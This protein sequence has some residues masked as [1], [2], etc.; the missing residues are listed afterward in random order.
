MCD[1]GFIVLKFVPTPDVTSL[2]TGLSLAWPS[3]R[4]NNSKFSTLFGQQLQYTTHSTMSK[5]RGSEI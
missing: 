4:L 1:K 5:T 2:S 3:G